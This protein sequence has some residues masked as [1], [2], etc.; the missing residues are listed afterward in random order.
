[1]KALQAGVWG[2]MACAGLFV[3]SA[4]GGEVTVAAEW[5]RVSW[6]ESAREVG[7]GRQKGAYYG[8]SIAYA[9]NEDYPRRITLDVRR[10]RLGRADRTGIEVSLMR[11]ITPLLSVVGSVAYTQYDLPP[12]S[13]SG[14]GGLGGLE[15][16]IPLFGSNVSLVAD[17]RGG[18]WSMSTDGTP[19]D[20]MPLAWVGGTKLHWSLPNGITADSQSLHLSAGYR[21]QSLRGDGFR[22]QLSMPLLEFGFTQR[23]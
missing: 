5:G 21:R 20:G 9:W 15:A 19:G 2:W 1:M 11:A 10:G 8:P 14:W 17:I 23:F 3:G 16:R 7:G 22:E 13:A 6:Q 18:L 4:G 12:N